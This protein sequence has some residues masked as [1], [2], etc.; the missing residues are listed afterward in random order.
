[1]TK[2]DQTAEWKNLADHHR[3]I[4]DLEIAKQFQQDPK[5][6]QNFSL[7]AANI[8]LDYSKNHVTAETMNLLD[9]L[10]QAAGVKER[11]DQ[12]FGGEKINI[13]EKRAVLH[14]TLRNFD[15]ENSPEADLVR[16]ELKKIEVLVHNI[17]GGKWRGYS[18]KRV[19]DIVNIGIGGSHLGPAMV[20]AAL[21]PYATELKIHFVS[22]L[23]PTDIADTLRHLN[24][25]TTLFIIASK[26]FTTQETLANAM[27]AKNWLLG[28]ISTKSETPLGK[29]FIGITANSEKARAFGIAEENVYSFW[30]WVGGRFSLWSALG[31]SIALSLGMKNFYELLS[32]AQEMDQH[33]RTAPTEKNLPIILALLGIWNINFLGA[34]SQAIIPY[35]QYLHL[36][37]AYLQQLEMES[38]GKSVN[39]MGDNLSYKTAPVIWGAPG[40]NSQHSFHQLLMQGT[41][42]V[43]MDFIIPLG[44]HNP[45][46]D[47]HLVLYANCLAQSQALMVG[48][49]QNEILQSSA[50]KN[51]ER[52]LAKHQQIMGNIPTNTLVMDKVT[53]RSLGALI[54]LYEH[55]VFIQGTIWQINSFDQW[56]VELGKKLTQ[57]LIPIL[58]NDESPEEL[59]GSTRGLI[60]LYQKQNISLLVNK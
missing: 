33:F 30:D 10:A 46:A 45:I 37:P 2:I 29:H 1:M 31:I 11:R 41:T 15:Q 56:G 21:K 43:P 18:G 24:H 60:D 26:T 19:T 54:A 39:T 38:N 22:N 25:E 58:Q 5:R 34:T 51:E 17:H 47:H 35:D 57:G 40:T 59:D 23:D 53:P 32:G 36:L 52:L 55:K 8:F 13:T 20:V 12:M 27:V 3:K 14:T 44:S 6:F 16:R 9:T 28:N 4:K 42:L 7:A 48:R 49:R 50:D